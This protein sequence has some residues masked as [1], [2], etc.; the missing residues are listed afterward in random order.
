M[1]TR[2]VYKHTNKVYFYA[3]F[4]IFAL[5]NGKNVCY[6]ILEIKGESQPTRLMKG[7]ADDV[8]CAS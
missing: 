6:D 2:E 3:Y 7:Y 8:Q 1:K 4:F 5:D